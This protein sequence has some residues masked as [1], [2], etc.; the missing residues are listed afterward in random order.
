MPVVDGDELVGIVTSSDVMNALVRLLGV[1]EPGSRVEVALSGRPGEL[2][3]V[4]GIL[5]TEG[6]N[7][8]SVLAAPD[9]DGAKGSVAV[10]RVDTI[11]PRRIVESLKEAGYSVRWPPTEPVAGGRT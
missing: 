10:F 8:V 7:I 1:H 11:D 2:A 5:Q 9:E 3:G 6:V 4:A